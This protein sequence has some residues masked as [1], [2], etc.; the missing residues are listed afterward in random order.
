MN[1]SVFSVFFAAVAFS[2][3]PLSAA[4]GDANWRGQSVTEF[5]EEENEALTWRV[6]NDGVMG[7][8][9][10][11]DATMTEG[12]FMKFSGTLSL[13]NNGGFSLVETGEVDLNLSNDL[14]ALLLVKGDGRTY[15]LRFE[16][17]ALY[18]GRPVSFSGEFSTKAGEWEQVKIPFDS[19][20]GSWRGTDL[21][22]QKLNPADIRRVG[23]LLGDKQNGPFALEVDWIRTYGKGQGTFTERSVPPKSTE[24][25]PA[26]LMPLIETAVADGRFTIFKQ[27]LDAAKLTPFFQWENQLTVFAPTDEA[28]QKLPEGVLEDLLRPENKEKLIAI[29]SHHVVVGSAGLPDA[30]GLGKVTTIEGSPLEVRFSEGRVRV[31]EAILLNANI[32]CSD[33]VIHVVDT[34]LLPPSGKSS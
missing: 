11:G 28:F 17:D 3:L 12:G 19:F 30:L 8:L 31:N 32:E 18:R 9:S 27:A 14:G 26:G 20:R 23:I 25:K 7:G 24:A 33:G 4:P 21:P 15:Q 22:A 10:E 16:S 13:E 2:I 6:V 34:V 29:L 5:S 1:L